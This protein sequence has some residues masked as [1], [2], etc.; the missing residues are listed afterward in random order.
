MIIFTL[1]A[2]SVTNCFTLANAVSFYSSR[3]GMLPAKG[4]A[5]KLKGEFDLWM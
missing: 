2:G 3:V 5:T 4:Y 1:T